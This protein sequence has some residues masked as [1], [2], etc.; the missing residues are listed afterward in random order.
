MSGTSSGWI[1]SPSPPQPQPQQPISQSDLSLT[2]TLPPLLSHILNALQQSIGASNVRIDELEALC[3]TK[4]PKQETLQA[5]ANAVKQWKE[6]HNR[7]LVGLETRFKENVNNTILDVEKRFQNEFDRLAG[8]QLQRELQREE[9]LR[10]WVTG[11]VVDNVLQRVA[12]MMDDARTEDARKVSASVQHLTKRVLDAETALAAYIDTEQGR[13]V[14][15]RQE[16]EERVNKIVLE[17]MAQA[18]EEAIRKVQDEIVP[19]I[20]L[21]VREEMNRLV[22]AL[23]NAQVQALMDAHAK[24]AKQE[25]ESFEARM[26]GCEGQL[27][28]LAAFV[29][30][31]RASLEG[32]TEQDARAASDLQ[33]KLASFQ[34]KFD[35]LQ[36]GLEFVTSRFM[37]MESSLGDNI[38]KL[39]SAGGEGGASGAAATELRRRLDALQM[40]TE[41]MSGIIEPIHHFHVSEYPGWKSGVERTQNELDAMVRAQFELVSLQFQDLLQKVNQSESAA[42]RKSGISALAESLT[43]LERELRDESDA[44]NAAVENVLQLQHHMR[45][46]LLNELDDFARWDDVQKALWNKVDRSEWPMALSTSNAV[47]SA[48]GPTAESHCVSCHQPYER[49]LMTPRGAASSRSRAG[50]T[51]SAP[52]QSRPSSSR[53]IGSLP[54]L[55][56]TLSNSASRPTSATVQRPPSASHGHGQGHVPHPPSHPQGA[57]AAQRS[58]QL[59]SVRDLLQ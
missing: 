42:A 41:R 22:Q 9:Q 1:A 35:S 30:Q 56:G 25:R 13:K 3:D 26:G 55:P 51:G 53:S 15:E 32:Q 19:R 39:A 11:E 58:Y 48:G 27:A 57:S 50:S 38:R 44:R 59:S 36:A 23:V 5:L 47:S 4:A 33:K 43:S 17:G 24:S 37:E 21:Q 49:A 34:S 10:S 52:Q 31:L 2:V 46:Q 7:D 29:G 8:L 12:K 45:K 20:V 18:K 28:N 14:R 16:L 6:E 40:E 54:S